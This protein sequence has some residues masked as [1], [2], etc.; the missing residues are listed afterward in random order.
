MKIKH[1]YYSLI[2]SLSFLGLFSYGQS[3]NKTDLVIF[4]YDRP[5]QL[6]AFLESCERYVSG[7]NQMHV[8]CRSS[9]KVFTEGYD[10]VQHRFPL[11]HFHY[12]SDTP[13]ADFKLLTEQSI[14]ATNAPYILFAVDDII[15]KDDIDLERCASLLETHKAYGFYFRLGLH[16]TDCYTLRKPQP[17][18]P[19]REIEPGVFS[20]QINQGFG[21][22]GY[23]NSVDL[24]LY[25]KSDV[26]S[27]LRLFFYRAPNSLEDQW[28]LRFAQATGRLRG[29]CFA[30]TK[31]INVPLNV[32]QQEYRA[33]RH[34]SSSYDT[35]AL[36]ELFAANKKIDITPLERI[37]NKGAHMEYQFTFVDRNERCPT[38]H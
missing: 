9:D 8:V 25:R 18:P 37:F 11:C 22:W 19:L 27:M 32:V 2:S 10:E 26:M 4:S 38:A 30:T 7:I 28:Y 36:Q 3:T 35:Y 34:M 20:W 5:L 6:Y 33:N 21:D 17:L 16:L 29:L 14:T 24:V 1:I 15:I 31:M 13:H 23:P 12:Q